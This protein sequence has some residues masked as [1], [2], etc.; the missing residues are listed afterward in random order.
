MLLARSTTPAGI[1]TRNER[2]LMTRRRRA[3]SRCVELDH[4]RAAPIGL[5]ELDLDARDMILAAGGKAALRARRAAAKPRPPPNGLRAAK[6]LR[7]EIAE[8]GRPSP[9][10]A[11][12]RRPPRAAPPNSKPLP[13]SGGGRNSWP[14]RQFWPSWSYAARFSGSFRTS[15]ASCSSLNSVLRVRFL[16]DVRVE[17]ARKPAIR[18]LDLA[19]QSR[20]AARPSLRSNR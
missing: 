9:P 3:S 1:V 13:Q 18:T 2:G 15:L 20:C 12:G 11:R 17:F 10:R 16:A 8:L 5:F 14:A 19:L 7:E 4:A 6:Q